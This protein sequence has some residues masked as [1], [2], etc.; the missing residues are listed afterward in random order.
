M[1]SGDRGP[2]PNTPVTSQISQRCKNR[3]G[4]VYSSL[5]SFWSSRH[6]A[7]SNGTPRRDAYTVILFDDRV[8]TVLANDF[9][10]A[11]DNLLTT[12]LQHSASGGTNFRAALLKAQAAMQ[13]H[14]STERYHFTKQCLPFLTST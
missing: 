4:A 14:W 7:L 2:L 13:Q 12:V 11:P 5:H 6:N 10:S 3:L 8:T 1:A 9:K